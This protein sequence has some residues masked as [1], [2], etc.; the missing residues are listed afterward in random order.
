[1]TFI[2]MGIILFAY[3]LGWY[4]YV[5]IRQPISGGCIGFTDLILPSHA[6][7]VDKCIS[8]S[9]GN[10]TGATAGSILANPS[11]PPLATAPSGQTIQGTIG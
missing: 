11:T 8:S 9:F 6:A 1:M 5:T 3:Q 7:N 10:N 4:G 2:A